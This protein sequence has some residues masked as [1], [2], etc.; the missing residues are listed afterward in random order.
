V[1]M[2]NVTLVEG[3][4]ALFPD[5][6]TTRGQ[7]HLRELMEMVRQGHRG[8]IFFVVQRGDGKSVAPADTI[9][10]EYGRLLRLAAKSGVE[11]LAYQASVTPQQNVL[12]HRLPVIL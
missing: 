12:T 4:V 10:A 7:K 11:L 2:K 1:E 5:A 8:V 3:D 6:I 9:D